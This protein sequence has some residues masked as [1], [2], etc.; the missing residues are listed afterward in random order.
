MTTQKQA[1]EAALSALESERIMAKDGQGN[2][3]KEVTPKR[4]LDAVEKVKAALAE[5]AQEPVAKQYKHSK[6]GEWCNFIDEKHYKDTLESGLF[7][8]RSLYTSPQP[9]EWQELSEGEIS[10]MYRESGSEFLHVFEDDV[11]II[12]A[13][14]RAKNGG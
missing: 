2:Y 8:I 11:S 12:S 6:T 7:E 5:P 9:R 10:A 13:A 4:I 3:N 1:L 14:L